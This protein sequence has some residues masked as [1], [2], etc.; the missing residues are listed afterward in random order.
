MSHTLTT[1]LQPGTQAPDFTLQDAQGRLALGLAVGGLVGVLAG[2]GG[3][4]FR[5]LVG[6]AGLLNEIVLQTPA[7]VVPTTTPAGS[8]ADSVA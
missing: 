1:K 4:M 2:F 6:V 3:V 7:P 8:S 5:R